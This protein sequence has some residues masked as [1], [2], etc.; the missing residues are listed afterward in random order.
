[1]EGNRRSTRH[2]PGGW[3]GR[4]R[5]VVLAAA[6]LVGSAGAQGDPT[7]LSLLEA[8]QRAVASNLQLALQRQQL[9][10]SRGALMASQGAFSTVTSASLQSNRRLG[11]LTDEQRQSSGLSALR[12]ES[13]AAELGLTRLLRSG[14]R[15]SPTL[16]F[17]RTSD[18]TSQPVAVGTTTVSLQLLFP[19]G[20][21]RGHPMATVK[22]LAA[23]LDEQASVHDVQHL[24]AQVLASTVSAYW[25]YQGALLTLQA[26]QAAER[27]AA[28]MLES[29]RALASIDVVPRV[30]VQDA[31]SNLS[32]RSV[33]R[34][35]QERAVVQARQELLQVMG[36]P[37]EALT[38]DVRPLDPLPDAVAEAPA[39]DRPPAADALVRQGLQ[40]RAD[41]R[42]AQVRLEQQRALLEG[43]QGQLR[44]QVDLLV[45]L[46]AAGARQGVGAGAVTAPLRS[47]AG[48]SVS[49]GVQYRFPNDNLEAKGAARQA[50]AALEQQGLRTEDV[51]RQVASG[52]IVGL[53]N[54]RSALQQLRE[55]GVAERSAQAAHEGAVER[56]RVGVGS[57]LDSL[58][59]EDRYIAAAVSRVS[60]QVALA[61]SIA[62]LRFATGTLIDP[63]KPVSSL[64]RDLFYQP[65]PSAPETPP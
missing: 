57:V 10:S 60:A 36:L 56:L 44:P 46:S 5:G 2:R 32:S 22:E 26:H 52:V 25:R 35:G 58:Q 43:W 29:V 55:A 17:S 59:A 7:G 48:P 33:V 53:Q 51:R 37:L 11:P 21:D 30:Q 13:L 39:A 3:R 45:G 50:H 61:S 42:A 49:V 8:C 20:R 64:G 40:Q 63:D 12:S 14:I 62:E 9:E 65:L 4:A 47:A 28:D 18:N 34:I 41:L 19:L 38:L 16:Q 23:S 15:V 27:R 6:A 54:L 1:M 31:L 24:V